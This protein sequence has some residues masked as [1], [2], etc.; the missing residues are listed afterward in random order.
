MSGGGSK[1][2]SLDDAKSALEQL[3]EAEQSTGRVALNAEV[4][5]VIDGELRAFR[6]R[7]EA[8]VPRLTSIR[9]TIRAVVAELVEMNLGGLVVGQAGPDGISDSDFV[10]IIDDC[11]ISDGDP[12]IARRATSDLLLRQFPGS[13]VDESSLIFILST[14]GVEVFIL[15][16]INCKGV[17]RIPGSTSWI[18]LDPSAYAVRLQVADEQ[19]EGKLVG[20][21]KLAKGIIATFP[22][23]QRLTG[24]HVEALALEIFGNYAGRRTS[25]DMLEYFFAE[26]QHLVLQGIVDGDGNRV[27]VDTYLGEPNSRERNLTANALGRVGR[28]MKNAD[29]GNSVDDWRDIITE[30]L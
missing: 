13:V 30:R 16:A 4:A 17:V 21:L 22:N 8:I 24:P 25:K 28:R 27:L 11:E 9:E 18:N 23:G 29:A 20:V 15:A 5:E 10:L 12:A 6:A 26:T 1:Y 7:A 3:K 14:A 2:F 19:L